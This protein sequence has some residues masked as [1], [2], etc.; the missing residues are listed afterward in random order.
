MLI[1]RIE[2]NVDLIKNL[3]Q[4]ILNNPSDNSQ[5]QSDFVTGIMKK[6]KCADEI[7]EILCKEF[8]QKYILSSDP[9]LN[10]KLSNVHK[11]LN[12]CFLLKTSVDMEFVKA[13]ENEF[14]LFKNHLKLN[15]KMDP[16]YTP[17][18]YRKYRPSAKRNF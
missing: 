17:S 13:L 12:L 16:D 9:E 1:S 14:I 10:V 15:Y 5:L 6:S 18:K 7:S 11:M 3:T 2:Q 4:N 8:L